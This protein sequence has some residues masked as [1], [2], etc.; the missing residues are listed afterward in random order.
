MCTC[1]LT[2]VAT[3]GLV[4]L[5][6]AGIHNVD[7]LIIYELENTSMNRSTRPNITQSQTFHGKTNEKP[8]CKN[9][10]VVFFSSHINGYLKHRENTK[11]RIVES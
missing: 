6:Q 11:T 3:L 7:L 5:L 8:R 10:T 9:T 4:Q 1:L 2:R